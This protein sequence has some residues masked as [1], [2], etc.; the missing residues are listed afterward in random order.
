MKRP[1][2]GQPND[3]DFHLAALTD[4]DSTD[5]VRRFNFHLN[6]EN[7]VQTGIYRRIAITRTA[8]IVLHEIPQNL[9]GWFF[10]KIAFLRWPADIA[11]ADANSTPLRSELPKS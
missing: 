10:Y 6:A 1:T 8:A 3:T 9:G 11:C 2:D 5:R 7:D 4:I